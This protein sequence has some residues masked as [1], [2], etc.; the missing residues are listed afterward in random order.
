MN[1][2]FFRLVQ[3]N[4]VLRFPGART[5]VC[6]SCPDMYQLGCFLKRKKTNLTVDPLV[7]KLCKTLSLL[8]ETKSVLFLILGLDKDL[9]QVGAAGIYESNIEGP[10][11]DRPPFI[12]G[13]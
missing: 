11:S 12:K 2:Q 3:S 5:T 4:D 13:L 9:L 10:P 1:H 6:F 8:D 7:D